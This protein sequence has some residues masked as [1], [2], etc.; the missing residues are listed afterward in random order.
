[1]ILDLR[2][3]SE[4]YDIGYEPDRTTVQ[5]HDWRMPLRCVRSALRRVLLARSPLFEAA[6]RNTSSAH[7][8]VPQFIG[9][10]APGCT[11]VADA[12]DSATRHDDNDSE[13]AGMLQDR[14]SAS[15]RRADDEA[16]HDHGASS[17][18]A[19]AQ[20][21]RRCSRNS[22][23]ATSRSGCCS[24]ACS[25]CGDAKA[26]RTWLARRLHRCRT[27]SQRLCPCCVIAAAPR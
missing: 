6:F 8:A 22:R 24:N 5:F 19:L 23:A 13:V 1:M 7:A 25:A 21:I 15:G 20:S 4:S 27:R 18:G 2:C 10:P 9:F 17:T 12:P 3:S 14:R 11:G 16:Q 26:V